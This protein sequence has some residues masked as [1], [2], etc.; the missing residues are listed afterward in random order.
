MLQVR[1][2]SCLGCGL[3][4]QNCPQ[5]AI[6]LFWERAQI[7]Q[8]KCNSCGLCLE[9]CPQ[10]AITERI[11]ISPRALIEEIQSMRKQTEAVLARINRLSS[12][13]SDN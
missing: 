8:S 4:V 1:R 12:T 7:D 13:S 9:I 11:A 3:C 2:E 6:Y 10:G 5:G